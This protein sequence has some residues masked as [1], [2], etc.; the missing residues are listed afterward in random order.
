MV[1]RPVKSLAIEP[2]RADKP[3]GESVVPLGLRQRSTR[4][5]PS[6]VSRSCGRKRP[7]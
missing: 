1:A 5:Q 3:I 2:Y 7:L 4:F 6:D